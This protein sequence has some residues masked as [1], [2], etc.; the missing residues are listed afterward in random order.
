MLMTLLVII[1]FV[2]LLQLV[3]DFIPVDRRIVGIVILLV[4]LFYFFGGGP[5]HF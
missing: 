3:F 1:L 5:R 2:L 4:V